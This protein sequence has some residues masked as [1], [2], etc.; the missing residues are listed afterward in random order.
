MD[1]PRSAEA[2]TAPW[3]EAQLRAAG[4][5]N[6]G[7]VAAIALQRIGT[8][9]MGDSVRFAIDYGL[10][11]EGPSSVV[12]KFASR[13]E[14]SRHTAAMLGAYLREVRFY[15]EIQPLLGVRSPVCYAAHCD[16]RGESFAL[17]IEDLGPA[18][19]GDQV[20]GCTLAEARQAIVQAAAIHAPSWN[21]PAV[22][23]AQW[24][25]RTDDYIDFILAHYAQAQAIFQERYAKQLAPELLQ[26]CADLAESADLF[27]RRKTPDNCLV[28]C[29]YRLDNM[30]FDIKGGEE[31][32]AIVGY[33]V[34]FVGS[35]LIDLGFFMGC[36]I[37]SDLR[38][39]NERDLLA[40]YCA[41]MTQRGVPMTV[42]SI[43]D[44]YI[45]GACQGLMQAVFSAAFVERTERGD[46][47]FLSMARGAAELMA[48][49]GSVGALRREPQPV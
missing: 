42:D 1:F 22:T 23:S 16:E 43:W 34:A 5:L 38:R 15:R 27:M 25:Q 21:N 39:P 13:D 14:G 7:H 48:D 17:I 28:H 44:D 45:I 24:L 6:E 35:G 26:V 4:A 37:G 20:A 12:G 36:G 29:D 40:L 33:Q 47:N 49:H 30:L 32:I 19:T 46:V 11:G 3:L 31:P 41:E 8:G 2:V 18:R 10:P 9:Q